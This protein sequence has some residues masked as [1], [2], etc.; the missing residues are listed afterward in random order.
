MCPSRSSA[1]EMLPPVSSS[2]TRTFSLAMLTEINYLDP[3]DD[4]KNAGK[5]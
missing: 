2:T 1:K 3:A 4:P 5:K